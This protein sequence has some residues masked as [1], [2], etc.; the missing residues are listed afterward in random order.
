MY[1][2]YA[3]GSDGEAESQIQAI[4]PQYKTPVSAVIA[5]LPAVKLKACCLP[6]QGSL[7]AAVFLYPR[8]W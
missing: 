2:E 7:G 6:S 1:G 3:G 5:N 8:G 4:A